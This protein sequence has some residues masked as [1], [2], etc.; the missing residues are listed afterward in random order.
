MVLVIGLRFDSS[1]DQIV[2]WVGVFFC[3]LAHT[4]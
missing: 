4:F 2:G 3:F 1:E